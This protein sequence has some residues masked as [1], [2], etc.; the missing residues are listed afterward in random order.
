MLVEISAEALVTSRAE[1][2]ISAIV[3]PMLLGR[4]VGIFLELPQ[5]RLDTRR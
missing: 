2:L 1:A 5:S 4:L 3:E